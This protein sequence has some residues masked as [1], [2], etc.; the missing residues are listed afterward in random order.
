MVRQ[1]AVFISKIA[2]RFRLDL[3]RRDG[4][5]FRFAAQKLRGRRIGRR[6][7]EVLEGAEADLLR[8]AVFGDHE[9]FRFQAFDS[10]AAFVLDR[11]VLDHQMGRG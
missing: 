9:V 10:L 11:D 5:H 4:G 3:R 7:W 2:R 1:A 8:L 6:I